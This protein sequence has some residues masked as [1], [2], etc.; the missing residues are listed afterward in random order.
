VVDRVVSDNVSSGSGASVGGETDCAY[1]KYDMLE[2]ETGGRAFGSGSIAPV[3][4]GFNCAMFG[5]ASPGQTLPGGY[6]RPENGVSWYGLA[7]LPVN[8]NGDS[9]PPGKLP[10]VLAS[11]RWSFQG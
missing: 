2:A 10:P 9:A 6:C 3:V 8:A 7:G 1:G 5:D 11:L 4:K